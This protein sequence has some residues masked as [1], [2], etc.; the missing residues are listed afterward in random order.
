L[1]ENR[2]AITKEA[3]NK[4]GSAVAKLA[5]EKWKA[6]PASTKKPFEDKAKTM[7]DQYDKDFKAFLDAGGVKAAPKRKT[8]DGDARAAKKQKKEERAASG[9]PKKPMTAYWIF[10]SDNRQAI[11]DEIKSSKPTEVSSAAGK[12][13]GAL[14][15]DKKK[16]YEEKAKKLKAEYDVAMKK[17]KESQGAAKEAADEEEEGEDEEDDGEEEE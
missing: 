4:K 8:K 14:A 17:W 11:V 2:E 16:P 13:W 12:K 1:A 5:G 3:P 7:K 9:C 10:L 15:A 6:L